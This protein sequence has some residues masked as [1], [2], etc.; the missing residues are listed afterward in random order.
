MTQPSPSPKE[1]LIIAAIIG[2]VL[3]VLY[4]SVH[5]LTTDDYYVTKFRSGGVVK[6]PHQLNWAERVF[7]Y[8]IYVAVIIGGFGYFIYHRFIKLKNLNEKEPP[9]EA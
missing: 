9:N 3:L 5:M 7:P 8:G 1:K 4:Y 2:F 6:G